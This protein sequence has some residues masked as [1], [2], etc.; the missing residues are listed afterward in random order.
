MFRWDAQQRFFA[1]TGKGWLVVALAGWACGGTDG[2]SAGANW[3]ASRHA[4][5]EHDSCDGIG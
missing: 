5:R 3:A 1:S 4:R 2:R